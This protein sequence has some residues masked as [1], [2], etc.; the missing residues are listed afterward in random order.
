MIIK[1][2]N[3]CG[4]DSKNNFEVKYRFDYGSKR[5]GDYFL[6]HMCDKCLDEFADNMIEVCVH[7]PVEEGECI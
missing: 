3:K 6:L 5:D 1:K 2:C 7:N 4:K